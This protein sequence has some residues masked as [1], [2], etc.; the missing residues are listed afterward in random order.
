MP[1]YALFIYP[2]IQPYNL[3]VC[4]R[5]VSRYYNEYIS[6]VKELLDMRGEI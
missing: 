2:F 1:V 5:V 4:V 6:L 3:Y